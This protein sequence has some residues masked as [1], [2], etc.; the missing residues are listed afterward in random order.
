MGSSNLPISTDFEFKYY[1]YDE[2]KQF[3]ENLKSNYPNLIQ[4]EEIGETYE[5]RTM[6]VAKITN[7]DK[8][9]SE[10]PAYYV[11]GNIHAGEVTGSVVSQ[12]IIHYLCTQYGKQSE[13]TSLLDKFVFY[14]VPR[15]SIDGAERYLTTPH[16][17]RSSTRYWPY[18]EKLPGFHREDI[19]NDGEILMMRMQDPLGDWKASE[20]DPRIMDKR[21]IDEY[22]EGP[23]YRLFPEGT[24]H[25]WEEGEPIMMTRPPEGLDLNR[26]NPSGPWAQEFKQQG[27][28]P[29]PL[30][31]PE[32]R[33]IA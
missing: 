29:F 33:A 11:E 30:S 1:L 17:L 24:L 27:A 15:I 2:I 22:G 23:Y 28:G 19:N 20:L 8:P 10:K 31:E 13:I 3:L 7:F 9:D 12:Y 21:G 5:G 18:P 16:S 14:V 32:T 4:I 26:N 25:E 6:L